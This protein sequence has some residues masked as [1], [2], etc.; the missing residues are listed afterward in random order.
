MDEEQVDDLKR[1]ISAEISNQTTGLKR[2]ISAEISSQT[3]ELKT[4]IRAVDTRLSSAINRV[5]AKVDDLSAAVAEAIDVNNE[6]TDERFKKLESRVGRL[7]RR[8]A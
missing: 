4:E 7:E 2:E 1:F 8:A 5:E 3:T 6:Q